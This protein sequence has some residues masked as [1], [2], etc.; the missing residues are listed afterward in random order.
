MVMNLKFLPV[1]FFCLIIFAGCSIKETVKKEPDEALLKSRVVKYCELRI[2]G[3]FVK[4]YEYEDPISKRR[5]ELND[6]IK[7]MTGGISKWVAADI[8]NI[9]LSDDMATVN[10]KILVKGGLNRLML[11]QKAFEH[12]TAIK[13]KWVKYEGSW[14][15]VFGENN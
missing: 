15:H 3:D 7:R 12:D 4:S 14:Y 10:L 6:Y 13:Q 1:V 5:F 11:G 9:Q 8:E 2:R